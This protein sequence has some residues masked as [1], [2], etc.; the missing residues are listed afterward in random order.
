MIAIEVVGKLACHF[1]ILNPKDD[2]M[3][4]NGW[5]SARYVAM[6]L[7]AFMLAIVVYIN[8][9][10][11]SPTWA[12]IISFMSTFFIILFMARS[13]SKTISRKKHAAKPAD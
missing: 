2:F 13:W 7:G 3:R 6:L 8:L 5:S 11:K 1:D 10:E 4:K 9:Y 12:F